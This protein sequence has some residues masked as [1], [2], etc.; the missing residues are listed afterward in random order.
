MQVIDPPKWAEINYSTPDK[1]I[2][3]AINAPQTAKI[4][5]NQWSSPYHLFKIG[6]AR[7]F[8]YYLR[9]WGAA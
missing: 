2:S 8:T 4:I 9:R 5:I 3:C 6:I 1:P 7:V